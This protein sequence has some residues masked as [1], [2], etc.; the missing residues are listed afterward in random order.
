MACLLL[1]LFLGFAVVTVHDGDVV[2]CVVLLC[3]S[4][5]AVVSEQMGPAFRLAG[6]LWVLFAPGGT[7]DMG[8]CGHGVL[9]LHMGF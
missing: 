1:L 7:C 2:T 4:G 6:L 9:T 8:P 3:L 5:G